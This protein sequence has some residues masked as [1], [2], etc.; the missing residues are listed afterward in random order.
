MGLTDD[1]VEPHGTELAVRPLGP[2]QVAAFEQYVAQLRR[3]EIRSL[4][5]KAQALEGA[6]LCLGCLYFKANEVCAVKLDSLDDR[7]VVEVIGWH[8]TV[9]RVR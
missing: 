2:G 4:H 8:F 7:I 3:L 1:A 5:P 6:A 9:D